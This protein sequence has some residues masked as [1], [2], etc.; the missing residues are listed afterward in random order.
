MRTPAQP[1]YFIN[2]PNLLLV[3]ICM[4]WF[5]LTHADSGLSF[6]YAESMEQSLPLDNAA[7]SA[8]TIFVAD[9][10][11]SLA[12][13]DLNCCDWVSG[14]G[15]GTESSEISVSAQGSVVRLDLSAVPAGSTRTIG[16]KDGEQTTF[17]V[18]R[19]PGFVPSALTQSGPITITSNNQVVENLHITAE[20]GSH[21]AIVAQNFNNI[22]LR[23]LK[24]D[25]ANI[26]ICSQ[27]VDGLKITDVMFDSTSTPSA[28]PHCKH[29]VSDCKS[30]KSD[31]ADPDTR[32][33][34]RLLRTPSAQ[35]D[36]IQV[37]GAS[38]GMFL[39]QSDGIEVNDVVCTDI[40][41]PYP[42]GQCV[43][44]VESSNSSLKNFYTKIWK[45]QSRSEDNVNMY[46][47]DNVSIS[48]G[49]IDGNYSVNGVGVIAD[50]GSDNAHV[51][52]IDLINT[53]VVAVS[54]WSNDDNNVGKNF[55]AE[56]IR[57][58]DTH[59]ESRDDQVP[60]SQGLVFGAHPN[61]DNPRFVNSTYFNH[62]RETHS[63]CVPGSS[64]RTGSGGSFDVREEDFTPRA[65]L[66]LVFPWEASRPSINSVTID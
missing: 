51:K 29:G 63:W 49:F 42:R 8:G 45:D 6:S 38:G 23:N 30:T 52:N 7:V 66:Q 57:A 37:D 16:T 14:P 33:A 47:S 41:G 20:S 39:Y 10:D 58:K 32:L 21:C 56:N 55:L 59:C 61:S 11:G 13:S 17:T 15:A 64:C 27:D 28:G 44:F 19:A 4:P 35:L 26:G 18:G 40:R 24:I 43:Q 22:T 53:T 36:R 31:W 65:K 9:S 54:V 46:Q 12:T 2:T 48:E 60:S 1:A 34:V 5:N 25:H 50:T 62:C 3:A